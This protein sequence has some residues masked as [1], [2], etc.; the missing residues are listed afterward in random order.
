MR[1]AVQQFTF[2]AL[3]LSLQLHS[4]FQPYATSGDNV[5]ELLSLA[6]LTLIAIVSFAH[7]LCLLA[8]QT[9][10]HK[11]LELVAR[12]L[13]RAILAVSLRALFVTG[14][15]ATFV[16][17]RALFRGYL[18]SS[19]RNCLDIS[20]SSFVSARPLQV[21]TGQQQ[22]WTT[23]FQA[24]VSAVVFIPGVCAIAFVRSQNCK[25]CLD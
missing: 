1:I 25:R 15:D 13:T 8:Q 3:F 20:F 5:M 23:S 12:S 6:S 11:Q 22:P 24:L 16:C 19:L 4:W 21:L 18:C 2:I 9:T 17:F 7:R 10:L 14:S